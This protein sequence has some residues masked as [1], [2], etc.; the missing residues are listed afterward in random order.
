MAAEGAKSREQRV[1]VHVQAFIHI[2]TC[3]ARACTYIGFLSGEWTGE[4][5]GGYIAC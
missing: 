1:K 5:N 3:A 2:R 4:W